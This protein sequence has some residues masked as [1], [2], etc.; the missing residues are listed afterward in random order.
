MSAIRE[1]WNTSAGEYWY[2]FFSNNIEEGWKK[3]WSGLTPA[4]R[5]EVGDISGV[6]SE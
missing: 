3:D 4:S 2:I 5:Y 6:G 1:N